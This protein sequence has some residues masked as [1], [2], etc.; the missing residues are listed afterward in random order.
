V[1]AFAHAYAG[2]QPSP[3]APAVASRSSSLDLAVR[4]LRL[5]PADVANRSLA[6]LRLLAPIAI[7]SDAAV[8]AARGGELSWDAWRDLAAARDA[9][10]RRRFGVDHVALMHWIHGDAPGAPLGQAAPSTVTWP[11][12]LEGWYD[13]EAPISHAFVERAWRDLADRHGV[14]GTCR[15]V[16]APEARPRAFIVE[17]GREVIVVLGELAT[18]AQRFAALHELGHAVAALLVGGTVPRVVDEAAAAFIARLVE[19]EGALDLPW[20]TPLAVPA[21]T[22]RRQIAAA[23]DAIERGATDRPTDRPI[24]RPPWA[25]WN[26]PA[27]Q[28]AYVGAESI[29]ERWWNELGA[30]PAAG[31]FAAA[32]VEERR[33]IEREQLA[34]VPIS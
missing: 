29:A 34:G 25:L 15:I 13:R 28:A 7:E 31:A 23:L 4:A 6:L 8:S 12:P 33:R 30:M 27:A 5:A 19:H 1:R 17:P 16:R 22:R 21:R 18:P 20:F 26:D 11:A 2:G 32:L 14:R 24:D 10:A 9:A 3:G